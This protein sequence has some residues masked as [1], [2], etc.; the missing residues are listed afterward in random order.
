MNK[1]L[2]LIARIFFSVGKKNAGI[3][4]S[5][6]IYEPTVPEELKKVLA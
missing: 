5:R 2:N 6:G 4:S 1:F 3:P